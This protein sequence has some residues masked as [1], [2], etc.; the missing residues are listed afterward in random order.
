MTYGASQPIDLIKFTPQDF[1]PDPQGGLG[2]Y[3]K[4]ISHIKINP[5]ELGR[6]H[7]EIVNPA[8]GEDS[9]Y[10]QLWLEFT[11]GDKMYALV[12]EPSWVGYV[13]E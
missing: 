11:D 3:E 12:F 4:N 7:L 9:E 5:H 13:P 10:G 1:V 2:K 8:K 6:I